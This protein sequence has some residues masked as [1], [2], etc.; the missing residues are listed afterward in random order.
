[1]CF[2]IIVLKIGSFAGIIELLYGQR[3]IMEKVK[4]YPI[5]K[6][7]NEVT[8]KYLYITYYI[9]KLKIY[10]KISSLF[11]PVSKIIY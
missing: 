3:N 8:Y 6:T 4:S 1:M 10:L 11:I 9:L 2:K 5:T 7:N